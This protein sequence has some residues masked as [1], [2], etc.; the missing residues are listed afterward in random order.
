MN[1]RRFT[2]SALAMLLM[3]TACKPA[4][5]TLLVGTQ[6]EL[7]REKITNFRQR[8]LSSKP[9]FDTEEVMIRFEGQEK[10]MTYD[11]FLDRVGINHRRP[12]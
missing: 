2:L 11:E 7:S 8:A 4:P 6:I 3:P 1:R 12:E 9:Q 10:R 5:R